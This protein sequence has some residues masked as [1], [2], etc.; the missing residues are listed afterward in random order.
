MQKIVK[1]T[2]FLTGLFLSIPWPAQAAVD[3]VLAA[4]IQRMSRLAIEE[5]KKPAAISEVDKYVI[6]NASADLDNMKLRLDYMQSTMEY[7]ATFKKSIF[8][9]AMVKGQEEVARACCPLKPV[10]VLDNQRWYFKGKGKKQ[11]GKGLSGARESKRE[12]KAKKRLEKGASQSPGQNKKNK[13]KA[14]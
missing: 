8:V 5:E 12:R 2:L 11:K 6:E 10:R 14:D 9:K 4:K 13:N 1:S 3:S 7:Y